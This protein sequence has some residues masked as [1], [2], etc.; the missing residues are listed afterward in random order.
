MS[1]HTKS[2]YRAIGLISLFCLLTPLTHAQ[3]PPAAA[4]LRPALQ[5][6]DSTKDQDGLIGAV[7]RVKTE[8]ARINFKE[9]QPTEGPR[10]L[11]EIT[12]Y[13]IRGNRVDNVS[14]PIPDSIAGRE[15]YKYDPRGN[16]VEKILRDERGAV[17]TRE[18]YEYVFDEVGNW[19]K[20]ITNLVLIENGQLKRE[21][22]E[23]TYRTLTYYAIENNPQASASVAAPATETR[24]AAEPVANAPHIQ[25]ESGTAVDGNALISAPRSVP[26]QITS[27]ETTTRAQK[28]EPLATESISSS[29]AVSRVDT[30]ASSQELNSEAAAVNG[31]GSIEKPTSSTEKAPAVVPSGSVSVATVDRKLTESAKQ[32]ESAL[33]VNVS[34]QPE[35]RKAPAAP[36]T[37]PASNTVVTIHAPSTSPPAMSATEKAFEIY[38]SGLQKFEAGDVK[39]A[40][41]AYLES[42]SLEP[43]SAVYQMN[44]GQAYVTLKKDKEAMKAFREAIRLNPQLA[45]AFYGLGFASFRSSKYREALDAFKRAAALSPDMAKVHY[46]LAMAYVELDKMDEM[47]QEYR[48]LQRLDSKLAAK[49]TKALPNVDFSCRLTRFCR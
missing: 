16:V 19:T 33:G 44:L 36:E 26:S 43:G 7:R 46:G 3:T 47:I 27:P 15:E 12:T 22:V 28:S 25:K 31:N 9:G 8:Y 45:E 34:S 49:L 40:I 4:Q 37:E 41:N 13:G 6:L 23:I 24:Q 10:Q 30:P 20:M 2:L 1:T 48:I 14:Y 35:S 11:L 39:G 29:S 42:I 21:P 38:Q 32:P 5:I 17:M 18:A